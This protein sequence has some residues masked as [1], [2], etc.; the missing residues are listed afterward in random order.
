MLTE[1]VTIERL[2][3][4]A[5]GQGGWTETW[6]AEATDIGAQVKPMS[7][8]EA[9][10]AERVAP[11]A[12]YTC[13]IYYRA[14]ANGAPYYTPADRLTWRGRTYNILHTAD[15]ESQSRWLYILLNEGERS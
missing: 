6:T 1:R 2:T 15:M 7:G 14:D 10:H 13:I 3:R 12:A 5:D 11:R 4:S 9:R 8:A